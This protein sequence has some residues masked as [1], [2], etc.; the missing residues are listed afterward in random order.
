M[1]NVPFPIK[2]R[3]ILKNWLKLN[4]FEFGTRFKSANDAGIPQRGIISPLLINF[5]LNGMENLVSNEIRIYQK[6]VLKSRLK[7]SEQNE[8]YLFHKLSDGNFKERKLSCQL[9]RYADDFIVIC[10]SL[11]LLSSIKRIIRKFL[12]QRGLEIHL[13]KS[14]MF[15]LKINKPF[16]FL[17]YTFVYLAR[18]K[19]IR[20]KL[21]HKNKPEYKLSGRP[22]LFVHPSKSAIE[23]F[24]SSTEKLINQNIS[25]YRLIVRLNLKIR[26]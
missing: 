4:Y 12:E 22:R 26:G 15:L 8:L 18:T 1:K 16:D 23:F 9:I 2:N 20:S 14:R 7:G 5:I 10:S 17:G 19:F 6:T 3:H 25:A 11:S 24:K 13:N 21:L